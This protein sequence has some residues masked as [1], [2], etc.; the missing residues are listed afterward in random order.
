VTLLFSHNKLNV[1]SFNAP[2]YLV[3]L[4]TCSFLFAARQF[5]IHLDVAFFLLQYFANGFRA[6]AS[7]VDFQ[8]DKIRRHTRS[9]FA[10]VQFTLHRR[11]PGRLVGE[12]HSNRCRSR[13]T[14]LIC[15]SSVNGLGARQS[16]ATI[17]GKSSPA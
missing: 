12:Y 3:S 14:V 11:G 4:G 6:I 9:F 2:L 17:V 10:R 5:S 15:E 1:I 8:I 16:S 13:L 7:K